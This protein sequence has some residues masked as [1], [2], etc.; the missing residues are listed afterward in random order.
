MT[1]VYHHSFIDISRDAHNLNERVEQPAKH[2]YPQPAHA[3]DILSHH[4]TMTAAIVYPNNM[5]VLQDKTNC[6][7]SETTACKKRKRPTSLADLPPMKKSRSV[8]AMQSGEKSV[9]AKKSVRFTDSDVKE[10]EA[11][12]AEELRESW[13]QPSDYGNIQTE[14]ICTLIA[15]REVKGDTSLLDTNDFCVRGLEKAIGKAVFGFKM[16]HQRKI[17]QAICTYYH[18]EKTVDDKE[19]MALSLMLTEQ[20]RE[21][22]RINATIDAHSA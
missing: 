7:Q 4:Q 18:A 15:V 3:N 22:A 8:G 2:L 1:H 21:R 13:L 20:D 9:V 16:D 10:I 11:W 12:S 17:A 14:N 6:T 5:Q 19:V